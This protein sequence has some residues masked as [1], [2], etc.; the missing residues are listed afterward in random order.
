MWCIQVI[1]DTIKTE[2]KYKRERYAKREM[3]DDDEREREKERESKRV[4]LAEQF[5]KW[6]MSQ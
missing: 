2:T 6:N 3:I 4:D 1:H 5:Y